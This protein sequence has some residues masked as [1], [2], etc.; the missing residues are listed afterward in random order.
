MALS[1]SEL[2]LGAIV[3]DAV[4]LPAP[5]PQPSPAC[6]RGRK[7]ASALVPQPALVCSLSVC[8]QPC[9]WYVAAGL[10]HIA[11]GVATPPLFDQPH[12][13]PDEGGGAKAVVF[14]DSAPYGVIVKP[15][16][17]CCLVFGAR[18]SGCDDFDQVV[19]FIPP[20]LLFGVLTCVVYGLIGC[21]CRRK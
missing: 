20:E 12:A 17:L 11:D 18:A 3:F 6:G 8:I 1:L 7:A 2:A 14:G 9:Q 21:K 16:G 4:L 5:L 15:C 19:F 13:F 10:V